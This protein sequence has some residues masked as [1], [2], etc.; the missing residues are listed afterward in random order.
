MKTLTIRSSLSK[1]EYD[2][3]VF[4]LLTLIAYTLDG[5]QTVRLLRDNGIKCKEVR[6]SKSISALFK[7]KKT[8]E[9][10]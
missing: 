1:R 7:S 9:K 4:D 3:V 6:K 2:K 10:P 8:R 5:K